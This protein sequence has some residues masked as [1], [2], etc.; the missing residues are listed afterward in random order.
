MAWR[1]GLAIAAAVAAAVGGP[2]MADGEAYLAALRDRV[3]AMHE[4]VPQLV[5]AGA[6][7]GDHLSED[8]SPGGPGLAVVGDPALAYELGR[9]AG[10]IFAYDARTSAQPGDATLTTS[11]GAVNVTLPGGARYAVSI[12]EASAE[13]GEQ[14]LPARFAA[15]L[16]AVAAHAVMLEAFAAATRLGQV[17]VVRESLD[18]DTRR[19]RFFRTLGQRFH[20]DRWLDPVAPGVLAERYLAAVDAHL[21]DLQTAARPGLMNAADRLAEA[22]DAGR[23]IYLVVGPHGLPHHLADLLRADPARLADR[24]TPL[25]ERHAVTPA[26]AVLAIADYQHAGDPDYFSQVDRMRR[27]PRVVWLLSAHNTTLADLAPGEL[28]VDLRTPVGDA[29][30][31]LEHYDAPLGPTSGVATLAALHFL[32]AELTD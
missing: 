28:A 29:A 24:F 19:D 17:P 12:R 6:A 4:R 14:A 13:E 5:S 10:T 9:R 7:L 18:T 30:I 20:R 31:R 15:P 25:T 1:I 8:P 21:L 22:R 23:P 27:T 3:A 11:P 16:R 32:L 26:D 2:A